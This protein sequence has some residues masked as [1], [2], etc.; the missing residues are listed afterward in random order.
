MRFTSEKRAT[1]RT[2]AADVIY[3]VT[4]QKA[5][6]N[7]SLEKFL[8]SAVL[9]DA[10]AADIS[11]ITELSNGTVKMIKH[12]D[13]VL[14]HFLKKNIS[15]MNPE[16]RAILRMSVYQL[17]FLDR[18]PAYA[19][20]DEA[21]KMAKKQAGK[22][23]AGVVNGVLRAIIRAD[24]SWQYPVKEEPVQLLSVFY[25]QPEWLVEKILSRLD[26]NRAEAVF[27]FYNQPAP[28]F[29]RTNFSRIDRSALQQELAQSGILT[30]YHAVPETLEVLEHAQSLFKTH[31]W[32]QGYFYVQNPAS[33]LAVH[34]LDPQPKETIYDVCCGVGGKTLHIAEYTNSQAFLTANDIYQHKLTLLITSQQ[35]LQLDN[36][37]LSQMD[38]LELAA[39]S[40]LADRILLDA[41]CSGWGVLQR[42][43]DQRWRLAPQA[44]DE[45]VFLQQRMLNRVADM[46]KLKGV[47][48]YVTCTFNESENQQVVNKFLADHPDFE[49]QDF[50]ASVDF[51]PWRA[52]EARSVK[53]G[54]LT[55]LPG[56]YSTDGMFY[57]KLRRTY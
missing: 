13:W 45:M 8:R 11:L 35:R 14:N 46:V 54:M 9:P 16:V 44:I 29:I 22:T 19:V 31:A 3:A 55:L 24:G 51:I 27:K 38:M 47:I 56:E 48:L 20:V 41:P 10:S 2:V 52:A 50:T 49:L 26:V 4:E 32:E 40:A 34:I 37:K 1:V 57:A 33:T 17:L 39:P 6:A 7:L 12:L 15:R 25:S 21:V 53:Q 18:I 36:I 23:M 5:Y 30:R 43:A 28:V 42:R